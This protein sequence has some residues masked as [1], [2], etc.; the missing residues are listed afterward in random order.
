MFFQVSM[1]K[2]KNVLSR[3]TA[4]LPRKIDWLLTDRLEDLRSIMQDN[5]T[6]IGF[7]MLGSQA[8]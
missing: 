2:S 1:H 4:V 5:A 8:R 3:N 7:P 6:F